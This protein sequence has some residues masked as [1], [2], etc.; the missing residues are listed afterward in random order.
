MILFWADF[1][2]GQTACGS[3]CPSGYECPGRAN[4]T[5]CSKGFYS[6]L[7]V[8]TCTQCSNGY[9]AASVGEN[10]TMYHLYIYTTEICK[11]HLSP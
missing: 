7:G 8:S 11:L 5:E 3:Q 10:F 6:A 2:L 1:L 9:Y 4:A